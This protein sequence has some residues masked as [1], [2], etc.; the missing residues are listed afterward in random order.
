MDVQNNY[1][2]VSYTHQVIITDP[3]CSAP[4]TCIL[5]ATLT[6]SDTQ[7]YDQNV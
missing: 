4:Y 2:T 6:A 1:E 7:D 3:S 5:P